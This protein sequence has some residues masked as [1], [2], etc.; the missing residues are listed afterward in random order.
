MAE[1]WLAEFEDLIRAAMLGSAGSFQ[2]KKPCRK[3]QEDEGISDWINPCC[4][5]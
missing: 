5:V 4:F 3:G 2:A 1:D